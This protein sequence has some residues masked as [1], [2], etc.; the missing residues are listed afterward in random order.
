MAPEADIRQLRAG[1]MH[2]L[3]SRESTT[4]A[5]WGAP[6]AGGAEAG[7]EPQRG[8]S[9]AARNETDFVR[10]SD[11]S[12]LAFR[13]GAVVLGMAGCMLGAWMPY[14]HPVARTLSVLWWGVFLGCLGG[15]V[16]AL[17]C[18]LAERAPA[19]RSGSLGGANRARTALRERKGDIHD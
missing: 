11:R 16:G 17:A 14:S 10:R 8:E 15:S 1:A 4:A 2:T 12:A 19:G 3:K 7:L 9:S 18:V 6:R 13:I 5:K